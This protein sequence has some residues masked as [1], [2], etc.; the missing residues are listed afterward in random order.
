MRASILLV[1][2]ILPV[3]QLDCLLAFVDFIDG[4]DWIGLDHYHDS[5]ARQ[6]SPLSEARPLYVVS[7]EATFVRSF[8]HSLTHLLA[9]SKPPRCTSQPL[10]FII[11]ACA[12]MQMSSKDSLPLHRKAARAVVTPAK[13]GIIAIGAVGLGVG[14]AI[15]LGVAVPTVVVGTA[16][17]LPIYGGYKLAQKIR[18]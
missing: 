17:A 10:H 5:V 7:Y 14:G 15:A 2:T 12:G 13:Y 4:L 18:S 8:T 16:V 1:G 11:G 3:L 6:S 9:C